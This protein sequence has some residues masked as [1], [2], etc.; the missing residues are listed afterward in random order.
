M[1]FIPDFCRHDSIVAS[2]VKG[3][4]YELLSKLGA[5][6]NN[7]KSEL[8]TCPVHNLQNLSSVTRKKAPRARHGPAHCRNEGH[9][10]QLTSLADGR[11]ARA[12]FEALDGSMPGRSYA[13]ISQ[14][15]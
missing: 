15:D 7:L 4:V 3:I 1:T 9:I 12:G 6:G 14:R 13:P 2:G 8:E 11:H 10:Q 5:G